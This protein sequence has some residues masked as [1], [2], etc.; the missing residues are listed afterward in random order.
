M[1]IKPYFEFIRRAKGLD[2]LT[3]RAL[4]MEVSLF[5]IMGN[6]I[7]LGDGIKDKILSKKF[8]KRGN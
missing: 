2:V 7:N 1:S 6:C 4:N 8:R 3:K 5:S